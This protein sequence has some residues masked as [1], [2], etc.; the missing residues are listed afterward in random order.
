MKLVIVLSTIV[1]ITGRYLSAECG[2]GVQSLFILHGIATLRVLR[3]WLPSLYRKRTRLEANVNNITSRGYIYI[4]LCVLRNLFCF[5][6]LFKKS[7]KN[8]HMLYKKWSQVFFLRNKKTRKWTLTMV[9]VKHQ[10][11]L[12]DICW[13][14]CSSALL[15]GALGLS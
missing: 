10:H 8:M 13:T 15:G 2:E 3:G 9:Y 12:L 14:L 6:K 5:C 4:P 7:T 1:F 11:F